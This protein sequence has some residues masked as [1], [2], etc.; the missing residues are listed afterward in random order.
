MLQ[1]LLEHYREARQ[2]GESLGDFAAR[3]GVAALRKSFGNESFVRPARG[4]KAAAE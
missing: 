2:E 4:R 1:P 3:E